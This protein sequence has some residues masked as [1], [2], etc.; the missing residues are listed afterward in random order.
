[1]GIKEK[2]RGR[3]EMWPRTR[4]WMKKN[5]QVSYSLTST[6]ERLERRKMESSWGI[7]RIS[8]VKEFSLG[9]KPQTRL[10]V[11]LQDLILALHTKNQY[12]LLYTKHKHCI[13]WI[14]LFPRNRGYPSNYL[15]YHYGVSNKRYE[16]D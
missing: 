12:I 15:L 11:H 7:R 10:S 5:E 2:N 6:M 3:W 8:Q 14:W 1:M 16:R 4:A 13:L 9:S